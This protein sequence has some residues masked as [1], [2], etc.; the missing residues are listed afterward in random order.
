MVQENTAALSK[1][2]AFLFFLLRV[3]P[4]TTAELFFVVFSSSDNQTPITCSVGF[5]LSFSGLVLSCLL[6]RHHNLSS[7]R[8]MFCFSV[9]AQVLAVATKFCFMWWPHL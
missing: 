4:R 5:L 7:A 6:S 8:L 1:P 2:L 9:E 3:L